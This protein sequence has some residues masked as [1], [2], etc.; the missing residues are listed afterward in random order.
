MFLT[1]IT[2]LIT[3]NIYLYIQ[4]L[5]QW[6]SFKLMNAPFTMEVVRKQSPGQVGIIDIDKDG[7]DEAVAGHAHGMP[8]K[9]E[10]SLFTPVKKDS[11]LDYHGEIL[12][13][14]N[15]LYLDAS[16]NGAAG[17]YVF[18]FLDPKENEIFLKEVDIRGNQQ[19]QLKLEPLRIK[20]EGRGAGIAPPVLADLGP[21]SGTRESKQKLVFLLHSH[22]NP[23]PKGVACFDPLSGKL[24]WQYSCG[25]S[26]AY[27]EIEDLD[28]DGDKEIILSTAALNN[29]VDMNGTSDSFSYVIVLDNK[30][31][32]RWKRKT[33]EYYTYSQS[34]VSDLDNDGRPEIVTALE[35]HNPLAETRG[36]IY[37]FEGS[38]GEQKAYYFIVDASFSRPH[39][40]RT[41]ENESLIY[42]G[43]TVGRT[44]LFDGQLE[45]RETTK[46]E[47]ASALRVSRTI[48]LGEAGKHRYV[49]INTLDRLML[50]DPML[51]K[52]YFD[53]HFERSM[54][55]QLMEPPNPVIFPFRS[56][57]G[58]HA[59][60]RADKLYV[61]GKSSLSAGK[62]F[63]NMAASLLMFT[64]ILALLLDFFL[65]SLLVRL[66]KGGLSPRPSPGI[67]P[68]EMARFFDMVQGIAHQFKNAGTTVL[69]SAEKI[70]RCAGD[71]NEK[72]KKET[73]EKL[74]NFLVDDVKTLKQQSNHLLK[75]IRVHHPRFRRQE[76]NPL[77]ENLAE[78]YRSAGNENIDIRLEMDEKIIL[79][80][81]ETLLKEMLVNLLDNAMDA[82]PAGGTLTL[83]AVPVGSA[84]KGDFKEVLIEVEDTG[85]G[86]DK[87][88]MP[89]IFTPFFTTKQKGKGTGIGLSICKQII[90][91]HGGTIDVHSRKEF[92]T[93]VAVTLP[94]HGP[95][96]P[97]AQ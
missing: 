88:D 11:R 32:E 67:P 37:I 83:S 46:I 29:G 39:V 65:I 26:L 95:P 23:S 58:H 35:C 72:E 27:M 69:W 54:A 60:V 92:G 76:L 33:G 75:L 90:E 93:R 82:M 30:G 5:G 45:L 62:I 18:R 41:E 22:Y 78:H 47:G 56:K 84:S 21:G 15:Y 52:K 14:N 87:A 42:V 50:F 40:F 3:A 34:T 4:G 9:R 12:V 36:K 31:N 19:S 66:F 48:H 89:G 8:D 94:L 10:F 73:L 59:L 7:E 17:A 53:F 16:Y 64:V 85:V 81:D 25:A 55:P 63:K 43:D 70:K 38:T 86:I 79:F 44:W 2:V 28:N 97:P 91:T 96:V 74:S 20:P 51:R 80:M 6:K 77:L 71:I 68:P 61:L 49:V 57:E 1:A 24:L 13:P